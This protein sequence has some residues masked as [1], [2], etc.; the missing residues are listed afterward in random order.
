MF[1]FINEEDE[2]GQVG[3]GTLI[4]FIAMVLVAAIAA[5]VL[6][7]TAGVLQTQAESTGDQAQSQ[8][9]DRIQVQSA[10]GSIG[11]LAPDGNDLYDSDN[12]A[13][14]TTVVY[15]VDLTVTKSPGANNIDL[16]EVTAELI[17]NDGVNQVVLGDAVSA[18]DA[19]ATPDNEAAYIDSITA[20]S[21]SDNVIT[22]SGDRYQI[23]LAGYNQTS[24]D[25]ASEEARYSFEENVPLNTTTTSGS[26]D[27]TIEGDATWVGDL[28]AGDTMEI[29]LTTAA[30][31]TTVEEV[32]VPDSLVERSAVAL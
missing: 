15:G 7:N 6:I 1:E 18:V 26:D 27:G 4:V 24:T 10:S 20:E 14:E 13:G 31:A 19:E 12:G 22:D 2:R 21:E 25:G 23:R 11:M 17:T 8:V 3:I 30:G 28:E 16:D 9:S 32:V 5:G 29:R